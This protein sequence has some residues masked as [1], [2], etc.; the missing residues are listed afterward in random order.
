MSYD[1]VGSIPTLATKLPISISYE[2]DTGS[3]EPMTADGCTGDPQGRM[4]SGLATHIG[5]HFMSRLTLGVSNGS[6]DPE[7]KERIAESE[8]RLGCDN[9]HGTPI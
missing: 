1:K 8:Y 7:E 6:H 2:T 4:V 5:K 3:N 9:P